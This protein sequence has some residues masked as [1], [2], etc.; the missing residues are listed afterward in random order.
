MLTLNSACETVQLRIAERILTDIPIEDLTTNLEEDGLSTFETD[1]HS[2]NPPTDIVAF[3]ELRSCADL[4][5][6]KKR[7]LLDLSPT[8]QRDFV[9]PPMAQTRFIDSLMKGLPIPSMC[10]AHDWK[11][12]Q[13]QVIDGLQRISTIV[14]FLDEDEQWR[15]SNE[16]DIEPKIAGKTVSEIRE[17]SPSLRKYYDRVEN[18]SIPVTILRCDMSKTSHSEYVFTIFHRLNTG[19]SKLNNQEIRNCIFNGSFNNLLAKLDCN[20]KWRKLNRMKPELNYRYT[21]QELILRLFAFHDNFKGYG[22]RLSK[23]LNEYMRKHRYEKEEFL[24]RKERLFNETVDIALTKIW[25]GN[26]PDKINVSIFEATLV[27]VAANI[28]FLSGATDAECKA[29]FQELIAS[30]AFTPEKLKE[31]LSGKPRVIERMT[32]AIDIF[33]PDGH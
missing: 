8:F 5:R 28:Q 33:G 11:R 23:F 3:N 22:G 1:D 17:G 26:A 12:D 24:V 13:Y 21:K 7:G 25:E 18:M 32:T 9:W 15:L 10:F 19:G 6:L 27:G 31:G 4:F 20:P 2:E 16:E 14:K 30:S 29:R